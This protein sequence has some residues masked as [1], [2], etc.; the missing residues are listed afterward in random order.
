MEAQAP[1]LSLQ[2]ADRRVS[3]GLAAIAWGLRK[4]LEVLDELRR[5]R[6]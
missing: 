2:F 1:A 5:D 4:V 3:M 6:R